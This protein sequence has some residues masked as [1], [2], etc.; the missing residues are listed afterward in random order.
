MAQ[1]EA[2]SEAT[3]E[4]DLPH[5]E[6]IA[7]VASLLDADDRE[8]F[9]R[10]LLDALRRP[11][12]MIDGMTTPVDN[13]AWVQIKQVVAD[14]CDVVSAWALT[15]KLQYNTEWQDQF[16]RAAKDGDDFVESDLYV[17]RAQ[18]LLSA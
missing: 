7:W 4:I 17:G 14:A 1:N 8:A 18:D 6:Q 2:L 9:S 16:E 10:E 11:T 5:V 12:E 13:A 3:D 15:V